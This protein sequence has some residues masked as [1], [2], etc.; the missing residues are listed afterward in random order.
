MTHKAEV[1]DL[2]ARMS[3]GICTITLNENW[4]FDDFGHVLMRSSNRERSNLTRRFRGLY[5]GDCNEEY[6]RVRH[7]NNYG[8][9]DT[10]SVNI[11]YESV[12]QLIPPSDTN[13]VFL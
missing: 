5:T 13:V 6:F 2:V 7:R 11:P 3:Q 1:K 9:G 8:G 4:L 10:K 12:L